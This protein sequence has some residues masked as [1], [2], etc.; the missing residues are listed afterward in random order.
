MGEVEK[1]LN[2]KFLNPEFSSWN[3]ATVAHLL[4]V[5]NGCCLGCPDPEI[6]DTVKQKAAVLFLRYQLYISLVGVPQNIKARYLKFIKTGEM[7]VRKLMSPNQDMLE[8]M[9]AYSMLG[10]EKTIDIFSKEL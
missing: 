7:P 9:G 6:T 2:E 8:R 5:M 4:E 1:E 3:V 10:F